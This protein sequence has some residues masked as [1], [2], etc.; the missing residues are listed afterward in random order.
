MARRILLSRGIE[1]SDGFPDNV[2]T[3]ADAPEER[4]VSA[5]LACESEADFEARLRHPD[6]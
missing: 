4:V 6:P 1:V 5:A 3:F 2:S